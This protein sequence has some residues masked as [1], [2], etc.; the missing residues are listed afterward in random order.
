MKKHA[1]EHLYPLVR[2]SLLQVEKSS[3]KNVRHWHRLN[4]VFINLQDITPL[5][6][7]VNLLLSYD[8]KK[9]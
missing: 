6:L 1:L 2:H 5:V 3:Q 7:G 9:I 8:G 4:I